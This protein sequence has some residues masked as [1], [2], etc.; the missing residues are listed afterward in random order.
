MASREAMNMGSR[1]STVIS[2]FRSVIYSLGQ[3]ADSAFQKATSAAARLSGGNNAG[4]VGGSLVAPNP[5]F[6]SAPQVTGL[7]E[8]GTGVVPASGATVATSGNL[9]ARGPANLSTYASQTGAAT[10]YQPDYV[11]AGPRPGAGSE[12]RFKGAGGG[13]GGGVG[14]GGTGGS[15]NSNAGLTKGIGNLPGIGPIANAAYAIY[16][17]SADLT[18][19]TADVLEAQLLQKRASFYTGASV[20]DIQSLQQAVAG[21]AMLSGDN[22]QMDVLRAQIAAQGYG[23]TGKSMNSLLTSA[24]N[25]SNLMPGLGV[26]GAIRATGSMQQASSVNMLRGIGIQLRTPGGGLKG[27][28]EVIEDIWNKICRDYSQAYGKNEKPDLEAVQISLQPGNALDSMLNQYFGNDPMLKQLVANGLIYKARQ[29]GAITKGGVAGLGGTTEAMLSYSK[30]A[31][32]GQSFM[33]FAQPSAESGFTEANTT[34]QNF[35]SDARV[36]AKL[37]LG[38]AFGDTMITAFG[39]NP[40]SAMTAT[41]VGSLEG[42]LTAGIN[43]VRS[44]GE[45]AAGIAT[46]TTDIS[47]AFGSNVVSLLKGLLP[48][49]ATGGPVTS[50]TPYIVG[51]EGPELFVPS[52]DGA[53]IPNNKLT[54]GGG[55]YTYNISINAPSGSAKDIATEVK[56]VLVQL[57]TTKR[58]SEI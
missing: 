2:E 25:V 38:K 37:I 27:P 30:T 14:G 13:S 34:I 42:L 24:A 1:S 4:A 53:I 8:T 55:T 52:G 39:G 26:E 5:V 57:E 23:L 36:L 10:L 29:G 18:P 3:A 11:A 15:N 19:S 32:A 48:G 17:L 51:E 40:V 58:V 47:K 50:N 46:F 7:V 28:D 20:G 49:M 54:S 12:F 31:A 41:S 43:A 22:P 45:A 16:N 6:N 9:V 33:T 56:N 44:P 21:N 35:Y